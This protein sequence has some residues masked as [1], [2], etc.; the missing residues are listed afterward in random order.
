M[1]DL[2]SKVDTDLYKNYRP[3]SDIVFL[4]KLIERVVADR[5][6]EHLRANN[7][8]IDNQF[9]YRKGH[10]TESLLT[11]LLNNLL[12]SCDENMPSI[13]ILL[14]LSAAFDTVDHDL[15]LRILENIIGI[16]A[17]AL[18]WFASSLKKGGN[19]LSR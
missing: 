5:L 18:H 19:V 4:S 16:N 6:D 1:K 15:L 7:L 3:I 11:K 13:L 14:D 9:G 12:L 2:A 10:S 8:Y 17:S